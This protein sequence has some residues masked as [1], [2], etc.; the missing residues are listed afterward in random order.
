MSDGDNRHISRDSLFILAEMRL[1]GDTSERRVKVRNLSAGGLMAEGDM[2]VA[3]GDEISIN[4]RNIGWVEGS[5]AWVQANRFG[6]AFARDVD[7][8]KARAPQ[9]SQ[10]DP[11]DLFRRKLLSGVPQTPAGPLRKVI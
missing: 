9:Q 7:V 5:V 8:A 11:D 3:R 1:A 2:A 4:L 10:P 6:V